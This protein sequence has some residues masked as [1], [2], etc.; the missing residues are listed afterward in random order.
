M[1]K[2][3][4]ELIMAIFLFAGGIFLPVLSQLTDKTCKDFPNYLQEDC[5]KLTTDDLIKARQGDG[6]I[7]ALIFNPLGIY[8][9]YQRHKD[10]TLQSKESVSR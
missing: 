3:I 7:L 8:A 9:L 5:S 2:K 10:I 1:I 4:P 6:V